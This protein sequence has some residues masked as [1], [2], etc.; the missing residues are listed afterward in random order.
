MTIA[1]R[2][3]EINASFSTDCQGKLVQI[4]P[5][6]VFV[7]HIDSSALMLR[8]LELRL[9]PKLPYVC[10]PEVGFSLQPGLP[11]ILYFLLMYGTLSVRATD[12]ACNSKPEEFMKY[13]A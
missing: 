8:P 7:V 1:F 13:S 12:A 10:H 5:N 11:P 3:T 6:N 4:S 2:P 9:K